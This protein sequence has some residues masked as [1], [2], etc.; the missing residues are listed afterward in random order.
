MILS[1]GD[2]ICP[3]C[4]SA[5]R[6][7]GV[8]GGIDVYRCSDCGLCFLPRSVR[9][10]A[11]RDNH[12]YQELAQLPTGAGVF[13]LDQMSAAY[14]AQAAELATLVSGRR[15]L[16]V[17]CGIGVFV[18]VA[19]RCGWDARGLDASEHAIE[20]AKKQYGLDYYKSFA[21]IEA[22]SLD[23]VRLSHVL[24]HIPN[25]REFLQAL[26][27]LLRDKGILAITVPN[28]EPLTCVVKNRLKRMRS[29][30]PSLSGAIYPD[31]HVLGLSPKSLSWLM[32]REGFAAESVRTISMGNRTHY[33]LFFNGLLRVERWVDIPLGKLVRY[34]LPQ[35]LDNFGNGF[36]RGT[37]I[38]GHFRVAS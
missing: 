30:R 4:E 20:F 2:G 32:E 11:D 3:A 33:P 37:W 17:G 7:I 21:E 35:V 13:Y 15:L 26:R 28:C 23:V 25:P 18:A 12:W 24:E 29:S 31:M 22:G 16:D 36:G 9:G 38:V 5:G 1:D 8:S 6:I 19:R 14:R 10:N 27:P 34:Y